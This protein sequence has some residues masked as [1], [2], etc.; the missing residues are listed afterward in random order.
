[1]AGAPPRIMIITVARV[2]LLTPNLPPS[3]GLRMSLTRLECLTHL[4]LRIS[5]LA[6]TRHFTTM[7]TE[8]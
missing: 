4:T 2:I 6:T 7:M 5:S 8:D 1:M 3:G